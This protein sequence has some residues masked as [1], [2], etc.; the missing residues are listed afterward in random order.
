M[1]PKHAVRGEKWAEIPA[2]IVV[3]LLNSYFSCVGD[4]RKPAAIVGQ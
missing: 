4:Q 3:I 1:E 2:T